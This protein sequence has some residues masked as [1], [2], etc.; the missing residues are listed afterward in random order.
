MIEIIVIR[1]D[2]EAESIIFSSLALSYCLT[3]YGRDARTAAIPGNSYPPFHAFNWRPLC[4]TRW[5]RI[6]TCFDLD[7]HSIN[8]HPRSGSLYPI[9]DSL[10]PRYEHRTSGCALHSPPIQ[11]HPID[12]IT[13]I[14]IRTRRPPKHR[15]NLHEPP[16]LRLVEPHAHR[17]HPAAG[18]RLPLL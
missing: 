2:G 6:D 4:C 3:I 11:I 15:I 8:A 9:A 1:I 14:L 5:C 16:H 17:D 18:Q 13:R 7:P 12:R 10:W